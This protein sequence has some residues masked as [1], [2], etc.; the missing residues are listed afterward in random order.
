MSLKHWVFVELA[1]SSKDDKGRAKHGNVINVFIRRMISCRNYNSLVVP[2]CSFAG[3]KQAYDGFPGQL[4][5]NQTGMNYQ[6]NLK[7]VKKHNS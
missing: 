7:W 3:Y 4:I 6:T 5:L 1:V 2:K